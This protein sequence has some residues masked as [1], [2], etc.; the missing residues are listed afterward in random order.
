M[1]DT[2]QEFVVRLG[3]QIDNSGFQQMLSL[4][5]SNKLKALG[6]TAALSAATTAV[7]KFVESV[8]KEEFEL[9]QLSKT[10]GKTIED[11]RAQETALKSMGMT[12]KDINKDGDLKKIYNDI[13]ETNKALAL[14]NLE[15]TL[16]NVRELQGS[17]W[18]LK[19]VADYAVEWIG[20]KVLANLEEPINRITEVFNKVSTWLRDNIHSV[21]TKIAT[22]I[23][24]FSK[25]VYGIAEGVGK[26]FNWITELP[27]GVKSIGVAIVGLWALIKSGPIGQILTAVT[28][29]GDLIHD[30]ENYQWNKTQ[31]EDKQ[32]E[33]GLPDLWKTLDEEGLAGVLHKLMTSMGDAL[34]KAAEGVEGI[35]LMKVLFG[36]KFGD[37]SAEDIVLGLFHSV[38]DKA[39]KVLNSENAQVIGADVEVFANALINVLAE[40]INNALDLLI[41]TDFSKEDGGIFG[42][43]SDMLIKLVQFLGTAIKSISFAEIGADIGTFVNGLIGRISDFI[44]ESSTNGSEFFG[45]L[46]DAGSS[47]AKGI[48]DIIISGM[49]ALTD[50]DPKTNQSGIGKLADSL[51]TAF[52]NA[53]SDLY[54]R[55]TSE[56]GS[57]GHIDISGTFSQIG[58]KIGEALTGA[59]TIG[60]DFLN[61]LITSANDWI[62]NGGAEQLVDIGKEII[63]GITEGAGNILT[64]LFGENGALDQSSDIVKNAQSLMENLFSFLGDVL[65]TVD[66]SDFI[67]SFFEFL[68]TAIESALDLAIGKAGEDDAGLIGFA[69]SFVR[70]VVGFIGKAIEKVPFVDIGDQIGTF[71]NGLIN[72]ISLFIAETSDENSDYFG[73]LIDVGYNLLKGILTTIA[74]ALSQIN[75]DDVKALADAIWDSIKKAIESLSSRVGGTGENAIDATEIGEKLGSAIGKAIAIGIEFLSQFATDA[76]TWINGEGNEKL[77]AI[78]KA[79][80]DALLAGVGSLQEAINE[81]IFGKG[82]NEKPTEGT[83]ADK[84][85]DKTKIIDSQGNVITVDKRTAKDLREANVK[86]TSGATSI[87]GYQTREKGVW[88]PGMESYGSEIYNKRTTSNTTKMAITALRERLASMLYSALDSNNMK[89]FAYLSQLFSMNPGET[90]GQIIGLRKALDEYSKNKGAPEDFDYEAAW[91]GLIKY[92]G[93]STENS[94]KKVESSATIFSSATTLATSAIRNFRNELNSF[95]LPDFSS[96]DDSEEEGKAFGG[97]V[98]REDTYRL[99]E[100]NNPEYVIPITKPDRAFELIMQMFGEMGSG[101]LNRVMNGLG[102]G[103]SGT[104]GG[105]IGNIAAAMQ[106]MS[107]SNTYNISAPVT[108]YINSTANAEDVG[109]TA[110]N[111]IERHMIRTL[112]G[113]YG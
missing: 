45:A 59:I 35:D 94:D 49:G 28:L 36:S 17:F 76:L 97:R 108:M 16:K 78:G 26:I 5:D 104:I 91:D 84:G 111:H 79:I 39:E 100:G 56:I 81:A 105:S 11:L 14:P 70:N 80:R 34:R 103:Q 63:K 12:L 102:I 41:G 98:A 96:D 90:Q 95:T 27:D 53:I 25:G 110:Y 43:V 47:L 83:Y 32:V 22:Y 8:T 44:I 93:E 1:A 71:I 46:F 6:V 69:F 55:M 21:S 99:A 74:S 42:A 2:I 10:K 38:T 23:T 4:L 51:F 18:K 73:S 31:P 40:G 13:N 85:E 24:A 82:I 37:Q 113:V 77:K 20:I 61:G 64:A 75:L 101:M 29:I 3:T 50:V 60:S 62:T 7:Y 9:K 72:K 58:G 15:A 68:S 33:I 57:D 66:L 87:W 88:L 112:R 52:S 109:T 65:D 92:F 89:D 54:Q 107:I 48:L 19:S 30:Y 106:G 67:D 86:F